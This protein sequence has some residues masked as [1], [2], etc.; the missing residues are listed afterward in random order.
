[1]EEVFDSEKHYDDQ[2]IKDK[3]NLI[4]TL[5]QFDL[6]YVS[7]GKLIGS[8]GSPSKALEEFI[9]DRDL[10]SINLEFD[11]AL[12]NVEINPRETVSAASN[13][14]ESICKTYIDSEGLDMPA[15]QDIKNLWTVVRKR[16]G[17][18]PG[19]IEDQDLQRILSGLI[20]IFD[21]IGSL[22]THASSA[23]GAGK[24]IYNLEPRHVRLAVHSAHTVALF[25]L[26][27][28]GKKKE[29]KLD[30]PYT[31]PKAAPI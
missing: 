1:M 29:A 14:L 21:G 16:L 11:R 27:S 19:T 12:L 4:E 9:R 6:Q 25:V 18:D 8:L 17:F 24:K 20:S 23:H 3:E 2:K 28:W 31:Q 13:I 30:S 10:A 15:K 22:R 5:A 7:G 26:E